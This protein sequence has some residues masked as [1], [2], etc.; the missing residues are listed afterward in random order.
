MPAHGNGRTSGQTGGGRHG[1]DD[2]KGGRGDGKGQTAAGRGRDRLTGR[3]A[4][5]GAPEQS[6]GRRAS[7][8]AEH[9]QVVRWTPWG[10]TSVTRSRGTGEGDMR[11]RWHRR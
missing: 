2:G 10:G 6:R 11:D 1:K 4:D 7:R 9:T 5:S 8:R 3:D